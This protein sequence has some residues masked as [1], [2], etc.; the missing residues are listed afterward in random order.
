MVNKKFV[1]KHPLIHSGC[2]YDNL[3][4]PN[5]QWLHLHDHNI[6]QVTYFFFMNCKAFHKFYHYSLNPSSPKLHVGAAFILV[7]F[8]MQSHKHSQSHVAEA[9][10]TTPYYV[11]IAT[12]QQISKI[13]KQSQAES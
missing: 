9:K 7:C 6:F 4:P 10:F 1:A 12:S 5:W 11:L 2:K 13:E 8:F 3:Q